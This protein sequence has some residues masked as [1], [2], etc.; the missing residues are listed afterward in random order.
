[1]SAIKF[2][3]V[4]NLLEDLNKVHSILWELINHRPLV[5]ESTVREAFN[6][7]YNVIHFLRNIP[8]IVELRKQCE[9]EEEPEEEEKHEEEEE[10]PDS[11]PESEQQEEEE[12]NNEEEEQNEEEEERP[13]SPVR[14]CPQ[15]FPSATRERYPFSVLNIKLPNSKKYE[16]K[17]YQ[18]YRTQYTEALALI[19]RLELCHPDLEFDDMRI[20]LTSI[21]V[22]L[23][24]LELQVKNVE[25]IFNNYYT[26]NKEF[27][28]NTV[29]QQL[30]KKIFKLK[31]IVAQ[32]QLKVASLKSA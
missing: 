32:A 18:S 27:R 13:K 21:A 23:E 14:K 15:S 4:Q 19:N 12:E 28:K 5:G 17:F 26:H 25:S 9:E 22:N 3:D 29:A 10:I 11:L 2:A 20:H 16:R 7:T 8:V 6:K 30:R 31:Q 1:M 24:D